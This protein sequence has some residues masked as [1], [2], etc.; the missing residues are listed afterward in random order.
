MKKEVVKLKSA[1]KLYKEFDNTCTSRAMI[2]KTGIYANLIYIIEVIFIVLVIFL[3]YFYKLGFKLNAKSFEMIS[4]HDGKSFLCYIGE[5]L[6]FMFITVITLF[7]GENFLANKVMDT[8][9]IEEKKYKKIFNETSEVD[10]NK[11]IKKKWYK[12]AI[13]KVI[14]KIQVPSVNET[15][16]EYLEEEKEKFIKKQLQGYSKEQL[17][18]IYKFMENSI[19]SISLEI[20]NTSNINIYVSFLTIFLTVFLTNLLSFNKIENKKDIIIVLVFT[21]IV[22]VSS[23]FFYKFLIYLYKKYETNFLLGYLKKEGKQMKQFIEVLKDVIINYDYYFNGKENIS[24]V[25]KQFSLD[26]GNRSFS[27]K[28]MK[29]D[30]NKLKARFLHRSKK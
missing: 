6:F 25:G 7:F 27:L 26:I 29:N 4:I 1:E 19:R 23:Y 18:T 5:L 2:K 8:F 28:N 17:M 9:G 30:I 12:K 16:K 3:Y 14:S 10:I 15:I 24:E 11:S 20:A 13:H 22:I 21:L